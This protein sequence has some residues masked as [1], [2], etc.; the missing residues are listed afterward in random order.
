MAGITGLGTTY[1]LPNFHGD[2]IEITP[3]DTPLL[4]GAGGLNGGGGQ[5]TSPAFEWQ[6]EDLRDPEI[7]PRLE[8]ADA[9]SAESRAR[10]N[11]ENVVQIFQEQVATSYTK[12]AA[13]GQYGTAES[14]PFYS[15]DGSANPVA[16]EHGHQVANALKTIARDV[17]YTF[18]HGKLAKPTSNANPRQTAGLLSVITANRIADGEVSGTTAT[19]TVTATHAYTNGDKIVITDP[20]STGLRD[21]RVYYVVNVSTTVS[22]KVAATSGGSA[23]TL[24]TSSTF[25]SIEAGTTL[26]VDGLGVLMQSVFDNGGISEQDTATLFTSSRQKR[27]LTAAYAAEYGKADPYAGTRNVGGLNVQTIETDF[28]TLNVV[29]DR[30]LPPDA[31]AVVSLEQVQ[32]VFLSIPGKGVLFE[33]E[34]AKTGSSTKSQIYGEIGL[35]YGNALAHGVLRGLAV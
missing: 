6:T 7:R 24:G 13:T 1:N 15:S 10:D 33:E 28:G 34:L 31:L 21:D 5:T 18:W 3:T 16:D 29:I 19:D 27:A 8:G 17:N 14:A 30:A 12:Q 11:V 25:K 32:P 4:S 23:I 35:K 20:G 26:T 2:L 9:P 22:F